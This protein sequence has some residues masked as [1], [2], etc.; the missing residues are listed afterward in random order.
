MTL[1]K[2]HKIIIGI[3]CLAI[4]IGVYM[5]FDNKARQEQDKFTDI[6]STS[7]TSPFAISTT[8]KDGMINVKGPGYTIEQ[9]PISEG[10]VIPKPIPDLNR[11]TPAEVKNMSPEA[12]TEITGKIK[13]LQGILKN[14]P[15]RIVEWTN[16]GMYQKMLGDYEG[17]V[18]SWQYVTKL[19]PNDFIAYGNLGDLYAYFLKNNAMAET[20]FKKAIEKG[21]TQSYLYMQLAGL[22]TD[23]FKD[24][25]KAKAIVAQGLAKI[26]GDPNLLQLQASMK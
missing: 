5:A 17:T 25:E 26:P 15:T 19:A 11:S 1:T 8:T 23:V 13:A 3:I 20:Y 22:Y 12:L 2:T 14:D 18:I 24:T 7:S 21:P 6:S 10:V 9:V 4:L 16:L